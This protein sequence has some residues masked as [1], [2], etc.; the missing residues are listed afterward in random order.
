LFLLGGHTA[1]AA[2]K[3][4]N[5]DL[6]IVG[7]TATD[8]VEVNITPPEIITLTLTVKNNGTSTQPAQVLIEGRRI[9]GNGKVFNHPFVVEAEP[10]G[11][12]VVYEMVLEDFAPEAGGIDWVATLK[13]AK[14]DDGD[15]AY[16]RTNT[17]PALPPSKGGKD[18][19]KVK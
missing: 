1:L 4:V 6:D 10:G 13:E 18:K 9:H 11:E 14:P 15:V 16:A 19:V 2:G 17:I 8:I 5:S 12:A 7:F 3:G